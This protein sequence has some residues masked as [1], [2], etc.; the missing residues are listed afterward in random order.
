MQG[1]RRNQTPVA[2][3]RQPMA[4]S[5]LRHC[6]LSNHLEV[7]HTLV[8][9]YGSFPAPIIS[10]FHYTSFFILL[11]WLSRQRVNLLEELLSPN[12]MTSSGSIQFCK[13]ARR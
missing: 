11:A 5:D 9:Y 10:A 12:E 3:D 13:S 1:I 7:V 4:A 2:K 6:M 8:L